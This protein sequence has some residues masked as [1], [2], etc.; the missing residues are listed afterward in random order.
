M[1]NDPLRSSNVVGF[2]INRKRAYGTSY[3]SSIVTPFRDIGAFV[4][5]KPLFPYPTAIPAKIS[6]C[7]S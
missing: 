4:S 6:G 5:W 7:S 3:W 1:H 2:G